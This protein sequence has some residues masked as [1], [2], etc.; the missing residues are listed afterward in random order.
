M[1]NKATHD[2]SLTWFHVRREDSANQYKNRGI[3]VI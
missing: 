3:Q 1:Q 2:S